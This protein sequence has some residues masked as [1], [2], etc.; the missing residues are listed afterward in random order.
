MFG[1]G[2]FKEGMSENATMEHKGD[3]INSEG[4]RQNIQKQIARVPA[5]VSLQSWT[6]SKLAEQLNSEE[7]S[8]QRMCIYENRKAI[9]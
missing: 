9:N 7:I 5:F 8:R 3:I 6:I 2:V 4:L 1:L